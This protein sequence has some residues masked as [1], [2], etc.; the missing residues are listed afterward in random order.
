MNHETPMLTALETTPMAVSVG[1]PTT[2]SGTTTTRTTTT[3]T[4]TTRQCRHTGRLTSVAVSHVCDVMLL[5]SA[6]D[7]VVQRGC[8]GGGDEPN[9]EVWYSLE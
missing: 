9:E 3:T 4:T 8:G 7:V 6:V 1:R 5:T 2:S